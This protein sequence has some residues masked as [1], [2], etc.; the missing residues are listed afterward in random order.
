[1]VEQ[2][3]KATLAAFGVPASAFDELELQQLKTSLSDAE[4]KRIT[5]AISETFY[6]FPRSPGLYNVV[7]T[8]E[9]EEQSTYHVN[10][11]SDAACSCSDFM[12]RCTSQG[13]KCK[14]IWRIRLL[15]K[16]DCLPGRY[17]DPFSWVVSQIYKDRAWLQRQQIDT[18][19]EESAL[20]E[21]ESEI[22]DQGRGNINYR[23]VFRRRARIMMRTAVSTI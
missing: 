12:F 17:D 16:L 20:S 13:I 21:L 9:G 23:D 19:N 3:S 2:S 11:N 10:L 22:T 4:S 6:V 5:S 7:S 1:M 15:V 14:H 18:V 8:D